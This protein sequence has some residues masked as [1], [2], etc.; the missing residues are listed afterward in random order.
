MVFVTVEIISI[1]NRLG[2][3]VRGL[4]PMSL[5]LKHQSSS[6]GSNL[7]HMLSVIVT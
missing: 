7:L 5:P 6:A 3:K 1:K 4:L 2:Y